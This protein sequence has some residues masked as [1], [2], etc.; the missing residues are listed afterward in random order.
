MAKLRK[1]MKKPTSFVVAV[2]LDLETEGFS[3]R[4]WGGS[5]TCKQGDW[6]VDNAGEVYSVDAEVF[7]RTYRPLGAGRHAKVTPVWA[8]VAE[9]AG[10][11]ETKEGVTHYESGD[12]I[13]FNE[14][15]GG[16]GYAMT[17]EAFHEMYEPA[18]PS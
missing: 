10:A 4:K 1:Y 9:H 12:Y 6:L 13:V 7:E 5:Q 17:A 16:D 11:I 15:D 2:R 3:Y 18:D 8:E 14:P